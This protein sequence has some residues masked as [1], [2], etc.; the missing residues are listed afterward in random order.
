MTV[1]GAPLHGSIIRARLDFSI[2]D[3]TVLLIALGDSS[4]GASGTARS[5]RGKRRVTRLVFDA[6]EK[7]RAAGMRPIELSACGTHVSRSPRQTSPAPRAERRRGP[8]MG[9]GT[10]GQDQPFASVLTVIPRFFG[11]AR[12]TAAR[13]T[14]APLARPG[15]HTSQAAASSA[16]D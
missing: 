3:R 1:V 6:V 2:F 12:S 13:P 14:I 8:T 16:A 4:C 10:Q 15:P 5:S 7:H 11:D 9:S